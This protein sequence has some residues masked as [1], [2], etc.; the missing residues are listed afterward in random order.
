M[1]HTKKKIKLIKG[2]KIIF[3]D[4]LSKTATKV[5]YDWSGSAF[6]DIRLDKVITTM[7]I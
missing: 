5:V 4:H 2:I 1:K 6:S 3:T 7:K